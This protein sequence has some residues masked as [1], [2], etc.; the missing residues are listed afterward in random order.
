MIL[1]R[2]KCHIS[3][4]FIDIKPRKGTVT[5]LLLILPIFIIILKF[6]CKISKPPYENIDKTLV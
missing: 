6:E 3:S 2:L 4:K 5:L 1:K